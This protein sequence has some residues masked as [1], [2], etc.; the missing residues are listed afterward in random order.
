MV[1]TDSVNL[2]HALT[3]EKT[4][5][6]YSFLKKTLVF[7]SC[8]RDS[9]INAVI[10]GLNIINCAPTSN[11]CVLHVNENAYNLL[12]AYDG[13]MYHCFHY[14]LGRCNRA[15]A[16]WTFAEVACHRPVILC[17][18]RLNSWLAFHVAIMYSQNV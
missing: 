7:H 16:A 9:D 4:R 10:F 15:S 3:E 12:V 13:V 5:N 6:I 18:F 2:R 11:D 1:P 17:K 14:E 8:H